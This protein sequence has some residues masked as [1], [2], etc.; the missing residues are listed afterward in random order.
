M[1]V[2]LSVLR[3]ESSPPL[4]PCEIQTLP[5]RSEGAT[6][7]PMPAAERMTIAERYKSLRRMAETYHQASRTERSPLLDHMVVATGLHRRSLIRLLQPGGLERKPRTRQ[8][9]KVYG[10]ATEDVIRVV[11]ESRDYICAACLAPALLVTAR[12]LATFGEVTLTP[13]V[14]EQL[15]Q[16]SR[17]TVGRLLVRV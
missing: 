11:G 4:S 16:I 17:A 6:E 7:E 5:L 12:H 2:C 13:E 14:E 9:G 10:P 1:T 3:P 8:R 15:G